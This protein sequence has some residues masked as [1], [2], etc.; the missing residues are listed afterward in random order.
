MLVLTDSQVLVLSDVLT[1]VLINE[2]YRV[3]QIEECLSWL[4]QPGDQGVSCPF[5]RWSMSQLANE[6]LS[7]MRRETDNP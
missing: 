7:T 1:K 2:P 5:E 4:Q 3:S 6:I